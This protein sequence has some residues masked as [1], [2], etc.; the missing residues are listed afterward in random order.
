MHGARCPSQEEHDSKAEQLHKATLARSEEH[1]QRIVHLEET[2]QTAELQRKAE[3]RDVQREFE[4]VKPEIVGVFL[5]TGVGGCSVGQYSRLQVLASSYADLREQAQ[6]LQHQLS[7]ATADL[8]HARHREQQ[9]LSRQAQADAALDAAE[10]R[11]ETQGAELQAAQRELQAARFA[12]DTAYAQTAPVAVFPL[13]LLSSPGDCVCAAVCRQ[14]ELHWQDCRLRSDCDAQL[15]ALTQRLTAAQTTHHDQVQ[16]LEARIA[17]LQHHEMQARDEAH[18]AKKRAADLQAAVAAAEDAHAA[19]NA[20]VRDAAEQQAAL[21]HE[22]QAALQASRERHQQALQ[23]HEDTLAALR[24]DTAQLEADKAEL[25]AEVQRLCS[26]LEAAGGRALA[27]QQALSTISATWETRLRHSSAAEVDLS[28][29]TRSLLTAR[30][31]VE[32]LR[33]EVQGKSRDLEQHKLVL[34]QLQVD[35]DRAQSEAALLRQAT[36]NLRAGRAD[37]AEPTGEPGQQMVFLEALVGAQREELDRRIARQVELEAR[38]LTAPGPPPAATAAPRQGNP[39]TDSEQ[40][41]ASP[42]ARRLQEL[43]AK[44]EQQQ[45]TLHA[46]QAQLQHGR[47]EL[48]AEQRQTAFLRQELAQAQS[49][50][51]GKAALAS[52]V[53]H[54]L[55]AERAAKDALL[56]RLDASQAA[57]ASLLQLFLDHTQRCHAVQTLL[58]EVLREGQS[59]PVP[60]SLVPFSLLLSQPG[61]RALAGSRLASPSPRLSCPC[62]A[63]PHRL[64]H[65]WSAGGSWHVAGAPP[66]RHC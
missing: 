27:A 66:R 51:Q 7:D 2:L 11:L 62:W 15:A 50:L 14:Q 1:Q 57:N 58:A 22:L 64:A 46:A 56:A 53:S 35:K 8:E 6:A 63:G 3:L 13:R 25:V 59:H 4:E 55:H 10:A 54:D 39:S 48:D 65:Q 20:S 29:L 31:Q 32:A 34:Q 49:R 16:Q 52:A 18:A 44:A 40:F 12:L 5:E 45:L 36:A 23:A 21:V 37:A 33:L 42:L 30:Q 26:E 19:T 43:Q 38:L 47:L 28:E 17:S 60:V 24:Q 61:R 41:A 9:A